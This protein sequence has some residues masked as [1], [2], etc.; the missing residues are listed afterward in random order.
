M[1]VYCDIDDVLAETARTLCLLAK[2]LFGITR[3]Y[4]EVTSFHLREVF[5]LNDEEDR[6]FMEAAHE[7]AH[8]KS[9]PVVAGAVE[10]LR[11]LSA[12]G[13][14]ID[15]VTGRP[16]SAHEGTRAWLDVAGLGAY[17]VIY[18][19]KYARVFSHR[20]GEPETI[21]F[22]ALEGRIYDI[23][24]DDSP[25]ALKRLASWKRTRVIVFDRPWN[26]AFP[27]APNM[28]RAHTWPEI[29]THVR[30]LAGLVMRFGDS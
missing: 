9:Y 17:P 18:A 12:A 3:A 6:L 1:R 30:R 24:I 19:D 5:G 4:E 22:D 13:C 10:G 11:A 2:R 15:L 23:A 21:P 20:A 14:A 27:L 16:A 28:T 7:A 8:L 25:V 29:V 26:R